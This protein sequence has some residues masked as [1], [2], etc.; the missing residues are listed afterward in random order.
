MSV[1]APKLEKL[2]RTS[3]GPAELS[4]GPAELTVE[5]PAELTVI[6]PGVL[7]GDELQASTLLL[8]DATTTC[9][10]SLINACT[11]KSRMVLLFPPRLMFA[12]AN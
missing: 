3:D 9:T 7:A 12:T 2:D 5:F 4:D 6:V 1:Q 8:P 10:P 11:Q